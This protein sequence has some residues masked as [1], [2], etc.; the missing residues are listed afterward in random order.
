MGKCQP[1]PSDGMNFAIYSITLTLCNLCSTQISGHF[2]NLQHYPKARPFGLNWIAKMWWLPWYFVAVSCA[3]PESDIGSFFLL[4]LEE[5]L[6]I[7]NLVKVLKKP[8]TDIGN[9]LNY[10][11]DKLELWAIPWSSYTEYVI[12]N[13][14]NKSNCS[15]HPVNWF[16][17]LQEKVTSL[18]F[19]CKIYLE[20]PFLI[21]RVISVNK[22]WIVLLHFTARFVQKHIH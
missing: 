8:L 19:L 1:N 13:L 2:H 4:H 9:V 10:K 15:L 16:P 17:M 18:G 22:I 3:L 12:T 20:M 21:L 5:C 11:P 7:T 6:I 14:S